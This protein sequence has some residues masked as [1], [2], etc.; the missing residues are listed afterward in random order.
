MQPPQP[1]PDLPPDPQGSAHVPVMLAE[2]LEG[3]AV[4]P[5]GRYI[6]G[7]VGGGGH[8]QAILDASGP[9]GRVLALD[10]DP[11]AI[12][13]VGERLAP[14]LAHARLLLV[15][16]PFEAI[17]QVAQAHGFTQVDGILLDLG[18]SSFQIDTPERGFAFRLDGPL[19]MRFDPTRGESA[20][21]LLNS[22]SE[23]EIA[24][25][26]YRLGEERR[27]R[28][29][30]RA[31]MA[32]RPITR[33]GELADVVERAVGG[34]RGRRIHPATQTFQALRIAVNDELGQLSRTLPQALSLLKPGGRLAV[35]T[36]HSLEDRIVKEWARD[37]ARSYVPDPAHP[38]GGRERQPTLRLIHKKPIEASSDEIA[39]NPRSRSARL[40]IV[41]RI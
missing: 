6:D 11:A 24:D 32:A 9:D 33:T 38:F 37:E 16:S 27:S 35:I 30:A 39:W 14:A 20:A 23:Q 17:S 36:F 8:T 7:T 12:H 29:I 34:R 25:L 18:I 10:A 21:D 31:I 4:Q 5:G 2:T 22:R 1:L 19:D 13:R 15:H 26:I 3:L 41:E 28:Q 40:R